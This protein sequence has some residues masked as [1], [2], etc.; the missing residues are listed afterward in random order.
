MPAHVGMVG[1]D[2]EVLS[3]ASGAQLRGPDPG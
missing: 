2:E 1:V 3:A